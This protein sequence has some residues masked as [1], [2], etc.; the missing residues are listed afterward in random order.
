MQ[1]LVGH[2]GAASPRLQTPSAGVAMHYHRE[3]QK[4]QGL[5]LCTRLQTPSDGVACPKC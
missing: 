5:G 3:F 4:L 1:I 2:S